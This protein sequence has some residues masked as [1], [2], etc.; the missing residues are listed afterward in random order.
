MEK[1][2]NL[3]DRGKSDTRFVEMWLFGPQTIF[4]S[5]QTGTKIGLKICTNR[6][7]L[8]FEN[9]LRG[10]RIRRIRYGTCQIR[11]QI[12]ANVMFLIPNHHSPTRQI[13]HISPLFFSFVFSLVFVPLFFL[14]VFG[15]K[16]CTK[17]VKKSKNRPRGYQ[18]G[19]IGYELCQIRSQIVADVM[20]LILNGCH[21]SPPPIHPPVESNISLNQ[22]IP[23]LKIDRWVIKLDELGTNCVRLQA[24][25][26]QT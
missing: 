24:R 4:N 25:L 10:F 22:G 9:R 12:V 15:L 5:R 19:R 3:T 20:F 13:E 7:K 6:V 17:W 26:S 11:C 14:V 16:I 8:L 18:I 2:R 23:V 21:R 1:S